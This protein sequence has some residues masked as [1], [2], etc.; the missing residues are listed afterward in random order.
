MQSYKSFSS[1]AR[2]HAI[3]INNDGVTINGEAYIPK[4]KEGDTVS[5]INPHLAIFKVYE[6]LRDIEDL[7]PEN[8]LNV[9]FKIKMNM[10]SDESVYMI[11]NS[12]LNLS[13]TTPETNLELYNKKK[14]IEDFLL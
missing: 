5:I 2:V 6:T 11:H 7:K 3:D 12:K 13:L 8:L 9:P 1:S 4:F 14:F 10:F